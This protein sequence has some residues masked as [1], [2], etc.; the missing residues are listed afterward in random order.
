MPFLFLNIK[1]S[2]YCY[3][4]V[5]QKPEIYQVVNFSKIIKIS[6]LW[7]PDFKKE[8]TRPITKVY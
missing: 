3:W 7:Q 5:E 4:K 1:E 8:K 2:D 6:I